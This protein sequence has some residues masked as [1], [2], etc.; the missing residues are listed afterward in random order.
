M[1]KIRLSKIGDRYRIIN[2]IYKYWNSEHIFVKNNMLFD[3]E[4]LIEDKI[5]FIIAEDSNTEIMGI[6]GFIQ[7]SKLLET[8]DI[9]TAMWMVSNKSKDLT[10]G[11]KLYLF[12]KSLSPRSISCVGI[13]PK[14][15]KLY[16][17]LGYRTG[18]LKHFYILNEEINSY[19]ISKINNY[20]SED[21]KNFKSSNKQLI[22][23]KNGNLLKSSD[24]I[25]LKKF[26]FILKSTKFLIKRYVNHPI[27]NYKF[28]TIV[29]RDKLEA[30][31]IAREVECFGHKILRIIDYFGPS[32]AFRNIGF[33]LKKIILDNN[34]EYI[35]FY[36]FGLDDEDL[37]HA[38]FIEN[39]FTNIIPNYFEPY[40]L[41][42]I[43]I[44]F[45]TNIEKENIYLF[46]GDGDQDRPNLVIRGD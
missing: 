6:L 28:L 15:I 42:N 24:F 11:S 20:P 41:K 46:K 23:S 34:Y 27:Y 43:D 33:E 37:Y 39:D 10:L 13:N 1:Y 38:G 26:N 29:D 40:I 3:Y 4:Y 21:I 44:N 12:L 14:T 32:K 17:Y 22:E 30:L 45:F 36:E 2:F 35:D 25:N 19:R 16:K 31:L 8:S 18:K 9:F 7:Y 5:N